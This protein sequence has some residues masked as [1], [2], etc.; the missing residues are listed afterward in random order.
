MRDRM[1]GFLVLGERTAASRVSINLAMA[2][3]AALTLSACE[4]TS[5]LG[6]APISQTTQHGYLISPIALQQ[7]A[8]GSS[9]DQVL[10]ALGSPSTIAQYGGEVFYYISQTRQRPVAF[11][12][13]KVVEQEVLAIYF[14]KSKKV[15]RVAR[16]GLQD[17]KVF[18]F[19][20]RTTQTGGSDQGF[21]QSVF[22]TNV[23]KPGGLG[24]P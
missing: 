3:V 20:S 23:L 8:V 13:D 7:V 22:N 15:S 9:R 14:E 5:R 11:L 6:L 17:G 10:V 24:G 2:T 21:L 18:D 1:G 16:Y 4:Q 19:V 12:P